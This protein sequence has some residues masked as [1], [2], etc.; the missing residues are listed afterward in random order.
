M[1]A[2]GRVAVQVAGLALDERPLTYGK[3]SVVRKEYV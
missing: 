1:Q 2:L 3:L